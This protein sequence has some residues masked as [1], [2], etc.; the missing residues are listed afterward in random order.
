MGQRSQIYIRI[1]DEDNNK[2]LIAKYFQWNY[3]ERMISRARYGIEYIKDTLEYIGQNN[4]QK[5]INKIFDIN[6]DMKDVALSQDILE[7]LRSEFWENKSLANDYIF[8][9]QDNNDGKLFIDCNQNS[10]EI[11]F[12]FT[13]YDMNILSPNKYMEWDIGKKW[14]SPN[15]Y[16]DPKLD[17]DWKK[18]IPICKDNIKF[19]NENAKLMT[20]IELKNFIDDDYSQQIGDSEFKKFFQ[21]FVDKK[22]CYSEYWWF[23]IEKTN[24]DGSWSFFKKITGELCMQYNGTTKEISIHSPFKDGFYD[25]IIQD[26][27]DYYNLP[28]ERNTNNK[29]PLDTS[30]IEKNHIKCEEK[31]S[32]KDNDIDYDYE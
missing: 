3:A 15:F 18:I 11:K 32:K 22:M 2:I 25:G 12:C 7:E 28:Y 9:Y 4:V 26:I 10:G 5:R 8:Q 13:D 1:T 20:D 21:E 19:I 6:F 23:R 16:N 14:T 17:E 24:D 30:E 27:Y 31:F 29:E